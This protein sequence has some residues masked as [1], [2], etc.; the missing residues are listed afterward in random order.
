LADYP[1]TI[2]AV[3]H[4][5]YFLD[6]IASE[7]LY[8]EKGTARYFLGGYSDSYDFIHDKQATEVAE[9]AAVQA[10]PPPSKTRPIGANGS[11][12]ARAA[13]KGRKGSSTDELE[14]RIGKLEDELSSLSQRLSSPGS[15]SR[16]DQIAEMGLRHEAISSELKKLYKEWEDSHTT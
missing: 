9:A 7:I 15:E 11:A 14:S 8:F 6:R 1:G 13:R 3:S 4:D 16:R 10:T 2:V 12:K 5:R